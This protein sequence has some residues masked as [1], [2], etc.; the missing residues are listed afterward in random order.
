MNELHL[1]IVNPGA[2]KGKEQKILP[3][4]IRTAADSL[5]VSAE[6][7]I[8]TAP[9]EAAAHIRKRAKETDFL[10]VYACG[11]DGTVNEAANALWDL[12]NAALGVYPCG[13]GNDYVKSL[14]GGPCRDL[15]ALMQGETAMVDLVD[16][17][18]MKCCNMTNIGFD[19]LVAHRMGLF[20]RVPFI[21]GPLAYSL[22]VAV[23]LISR[24]SW[25][26]RAE[27]DDNEV[28]E[29]AFMLSA[30]GV[31]RVCGGKYKALP[32]ASL[33]D[34]LMDVCMLRRVPRWKFPGLIGVYKSGTHLEDPRVAD[35]VTYRRCKSLRLRFNRPACRSVDGEL[36][37]GCE[38][39]LKVLPEALRLIL[40]K[41]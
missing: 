2:G 4:R 9:G 28:V 12:P 3:D 22:A 31:G 30:I 24:M 35:I 38:F 21:S 1:F 18:G 13:S 41:A 40:P 20:R 37:K 39:T 26:I 16:V 34:G 19:A 15:A 17:N 29:G 8:P 25:Q 11:G 6:I 27:F 10:R 5:R 7:F 14:P 36:E 33:T 32:T 23:G